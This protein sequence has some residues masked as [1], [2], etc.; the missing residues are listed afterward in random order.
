MS[1]PVIFRP[2]A[3][4]EFEEAVAWY[5]AQRAGLGEDFKLEVKAG[6]GRALTD[7]S[8]GTGTA[9]KIFLMIASVVT[10]CASAS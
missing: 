5:E 4:A 9:L 2:A 10:A 7:S 3:L 1:L 6:L 8:H